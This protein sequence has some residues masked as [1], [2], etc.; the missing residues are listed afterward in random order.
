MRKCL[1]W[2]AAF[3][4]LM[5]IIYVARLS[6]QDA[7]NPVASPFPEEALAAPPA[8]GVPGPEAPNAAARAEAATAHDAGIPW[9]PKLHVTLRTKPV[10]DS[11]V[12]VTAVDPDGTRHRRTVQA[13]NG[14]D[15]NFVILRCDDIDVDV[16]TRE[17]GTPAYSFSCKGR[18]VITVGGNTISA[19]SISSGDGTLTINN[20]VVDMFSQTTLRSE[21]M[22]L[23]LPVFSVN[24]SSTADA[25][26]KPLPDPIGET[27][28]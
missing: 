1:P 15:F 28:S 9:H 19:D 12:E 21:K 3:V 24:I 7:A 2:T 17:E 10:E 14:S 5:T 23:E 4:C 27:G 26:L 13:P 8:F 20:A 22:T 25:P 6:A 11:T 16:E 18:A